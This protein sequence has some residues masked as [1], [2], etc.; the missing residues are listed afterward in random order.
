MFSVEVACKGKVL[1]V[2]DSVR[3]SISSNNCNIVSLCGGRFGHRDAHIMKM[4]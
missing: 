4:V 2:A 3:C 1:F